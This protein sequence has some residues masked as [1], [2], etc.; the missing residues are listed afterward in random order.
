MPSCI[1]GCHF[2]V[3][4][5]KLK[6]KESLELCPSCIRAST[7]SSYTNREYMLET[8]VED[9]RYNKDLNDM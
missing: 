9:T 7:P 6:P 2:T 1:C 4:M 5:F 8:V 3:P